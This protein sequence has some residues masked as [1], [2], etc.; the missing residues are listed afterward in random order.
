MITLNDKELTAIVKKHCG[1]AVNK[2]GSYCKRCEKFVRQ[3]KNIKWQKNEMWH[4]HNV[5]YYDMNEDRKKQYDDRRKEFLTTMREKH[6]KQREERS[7]VA[8]KN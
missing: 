1:E 6:R 5:G 2:G 3:S 8:A 7:A 4:R